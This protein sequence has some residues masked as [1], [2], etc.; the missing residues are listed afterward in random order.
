MKVQEKHGKDTQNMH[1]ARAEIIDMFGT[2]QHP[3]A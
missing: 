2:Y 1:G 3:Q